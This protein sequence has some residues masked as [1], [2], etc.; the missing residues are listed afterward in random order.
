ME[1]TLELDSTVTPVFCSIPSCHSLLPPDSTAFHLPS[2]GMLVCSV[3]Y[4][5]YLKNEYERVIAAERG[6][7][8]KKSEFSLPL[9]EPCKSSVQN[10]EEDLM[11][12]ESPVEQWNRPAVNTQMY[13]VPNLS[14]TRLQCSQEYNSIPPYQYQE[15]NVLSNN[16]AYQIP[17]YQPEIY[18]NS[19]GIDFSEN[20]AE[21][22]TYTTLEPASSR[23]CPLETP[24]TDNPGI[25]CQEVTIAYPPEMQE[26][27]TESDKNSE[28]QEPH[29]EKACQTY[30]K[31]NGKDREIITTRKK[32]NDETKNSKTQEPQSETIHPNK[33]DDPYKKIPKQK[34]F[35]G[36]KC[37][38]T[39]CQQLLLAKHFRPHPV[40][41][42][43]ICM[44][45]YYHYKKYGK[46][47]EVIITHRKR[48]KHETNC[49][50][51]ICKQPLK[52][53][54]RHPVTKKLIC[55][56]CLSYYQR[57]GRDR[58]VIKTRRNK[59]QHETHNCYHYYKRNGRDREVVVEKVKK[60]DRD[61]YESGSDTMSISSD[62][63]SI[64]ESSE[65]DCEFSDMSLEKEKELI[66][67]EKCA[68]T[69]CQQLKRPGSV[70]F[71][72]HP[73]TK[74]SVCA[75][76]YNYYYNKGK[77][78]EVITTRKRREKS[79]TKNCYLY[80]KR[81][82]RDREVVAGNVKKLS[83]A[84]TFCKQPLHP[85][86]F[87]RHPV[88]KEKICLVCYNYYK[89]NGKDREVI[90]T[91]PGRPKK[92]EEFT[93]ITLKKKLQTTKRTTRS[94]SKPK[95]KQPMSSSP[96]SSDASDS[97]E[98][99]I[100]WESENDDTDLDSDSDN[101]TTSEE[102]TADEVANASNDVVT[103]NDTEEDVKEPKVG[104][105]GS[106]QSVLANNPI[107]KIC[108]VPSCNSLLPPNVAS[109]GLPT[110]KEP[111]CYKKYLETEYNRVDGIE[112]KAILALTSLYED[113]PEIE[114]EDLTS[115][116][117]V[118][119]QEEDCLTIL[120]DLEKSSK[121]FLL[122]KAI[123][124]IF[125]P[126]TSVFM[127]WNNIEI[128]PVYRL[129]TWTEH[130]TV[131]FASY[132]NFLPSFIEDLSK[133]FPEALISEDSFDHPDFID[134][135]HSEPFYSTKVN[136]AVDSEKEQN[137]ESH[138]VEDTTFNFFYQPD[139]Y[140]PFG[141]SNE[142]Q[143]LYNSQEY[144]YS[145]EEELDCYQLF[146]YNSEN[147]W[148][149]EFVPQ[150][151]S[152]NS[153]TLHCYGPPQE[154]VSI[155]N[156]SESATETI[157]YTTLEPVSNIPSSKDPD[158]QAKC[159]KPLQEDVPI[160]YSPESSCATPLEPVSSISSSHEK[161]VTEDHVIICEELNS[162][163][164][165]EKTPNSSNSRSLA[166]HESENKGIQ[167]SPYK[168]G[169]ER[170]M[171]EGQKCA[172]T[173]CKVALLKNIRTHP[174]TNEK[175]CRICHNYY[176]V[177][178]KDRERIVT[179]RRREKHETNCA[180]TFCKQ[181]L[182]PRH[183][184]VHP[185]TKE[186]I[187]TACYMYYKRN[188]KD[189]EVIK[190]VRRREEHETNCANTFCKQTLHSRNCNVHP[191][192]KEKVCH[193][194]YTYYKVNGKD[195]EV[196]KTVR[197]REKH[198]TNCANTFC[199]VE[200]LKNVKLHPVTKK[201]V[202]SCANT[203]CKQTLH[204]RNISIHPVTKEKI[205]SAC[206]AYYRRNGKDRT[207][208]QKIREDHEKICAN[209]F[210]KQ[211]LLPGKSGIHPVTKEK[212][213][214]VCYYYHKRNGRDREVIREK[215]EEKGP[216]KHQKL[217]STRRNCFKP[218]PKQFS[219]DSEESIGDWK[220]E[221]DDMDLDSDSDYSTTSEESAVDE[222]EDASNDVVKKNG[223]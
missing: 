197:K 64:E 29:S 11:E 33:T 184:N 114:L 77:D 165:P 37:A 213:C 23:T 15:S 209:T 152:N 199:K 24:I 211:T 204:R 79:E 180:N 73:A 56:A 72:R 203:F 155:I 130:E 121:E 201:K 219:S 103:K 145:Y 125:P 119:H 161:Q 84:N 174:V 53:S 93:K 40:T 148:N 21:A 62:D 58:E 108:N 185:A 216:E 45:C 12:V 51:T 105:E 157:T 143:E 202:C 44:N 39:V 116:F 48:E 46:D 95:P 123:D 135:S 5:L 52:R 96:D 1:T 128:F 187:C 166:S 147:Y 92:N 207:I 13:P 196:I 3:C 154:D 127:I 76:C 10:L 49:T 212:I 111:D 32:E 217:H 98:N 43:K 71:R 205:C 34:F 129:Y 163:T 75:A 214:K 60:L 27:E 36:E 85:T 134:G 99:I 20:S 131:P 132:S 38:N 136:S 194:C 69:A 156:A 88:T 220:S 171:F 25:S 160:I 189:R 126:M 80:Y 67:E 183:F 120:A 142:T 140:L 82:G 175:I 19:S 177:N 102:S 18:F 41:K 68:N 50:N 104:T 83:C 170:E 2:T 195:R 107:D 137:L 66:K 57:N 14:N 6:A 59:E 164:S 122:Q 115:F 182:D 91:T 112:E 109:F 97:E 87:R 100:D 179:K 86:D 178:G 144:Q 159:Y 16:E 35:D 186:K 222:I 215:A 158:I 172:N 221:N 223:N 118:V 176:K 139:C 200:L 190:I 124:E 17:S 55:P 101:S 208:I 61:R 9:P 30:Y 192:T 47:R 42:E 113:L 94:C 106:T 65:S 133:L 54:Y 138:V 173:F 22:I 218:K 151:P 149:Q 181:T 28:T 206:Y 78:R 162:D 169:R 146:I 153:H 89:R 26:R 81:H 7:V 168:K 117:D 31:R 141:Y 193:T 198:E 191:V 4:K 90:R 110:T 74:E 8:N 70:V 150:F 210:C 167:E 188:G 63:S